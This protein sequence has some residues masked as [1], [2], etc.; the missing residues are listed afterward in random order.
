[1]RELLS[2]AIPIL[3][4]TSPITIFLLTQSRYLNAM[5]LKGNHYH[6]NDTKILS[7]STRVVIMKD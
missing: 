5:E 3:Q 7:K 2:I 1:M 6:F 4:H